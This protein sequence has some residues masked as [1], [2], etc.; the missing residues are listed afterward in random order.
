MGRIKRIYQGSRDLLD[1][2]AGLREEA[3]VEAHGTGWQVRILET[4]GALEPERIIKMGP[5]APCQQ[6]LLRFIQFNQAD[7]ARRC[8]RLSRIEAT[9]LRIFSHPFS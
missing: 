5:S 6:L 7:M 4:S 9:P 8:A 1:C 3:N 2:H